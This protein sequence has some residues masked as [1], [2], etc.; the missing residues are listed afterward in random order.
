MGRESLKIA[1]VR[2]HGPSP[3]VVPGAATAGWRGRHRDVSPTARPGVR[4]AIT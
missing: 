3:R 4:C 2:K 1:D